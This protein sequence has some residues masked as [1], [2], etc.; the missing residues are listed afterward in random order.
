LYWYLS[1]ISIKLFRDI[2]LIFLSSTLLDGITFCPTSSVL[3][4]LEVCCVVVQ[5]TR[6]L[7]LTFPLEHP[8]A[9]LRR[10]VKS[11]TH[12]KCKT[13]NNHTRTCIEE[14][15]DRVEKQIYHR[16]WKSQN[17]SDQSTSHPRNRS[18]EDLKFS[19]IKFE[20]MTFKIDITY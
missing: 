19:L 6:E 2:F 13:Y 7:V 15:L 20:L 12:K 17:S 5:P 8:P 4:A 16:H 14:G 18:K 10:L 11:V 9:I 1:Q 3:L